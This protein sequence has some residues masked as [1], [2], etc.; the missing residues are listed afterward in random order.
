MHPKPKLSIKC[1]VQG[2]CTK[3]KLSMFCELYL[4]IVNSV[5]KCNLS[6]LKQVNWRNFKMALEFQQAKRLLTIDQNMNQRE[7][8]IQIITYKLQL[9]VQ[10]KKKKKRKKNPTWCS[11][12]QKQC[13]NYFKYDC[14][15]T[16]HVRTHATCIFQIRFIQIGCGMYVVCV[17]Y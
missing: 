7:C 15:K 13:M 4:K 12:T 2:N 1:I 6:T 10:Q 16:V 11:C 5:L 9:H 17:E 14:T 8:K 3:S